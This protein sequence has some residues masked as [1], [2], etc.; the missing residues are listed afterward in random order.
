MGLTAITYMLMTLSPQ[1]LNIILPLNETRPK[2]LPFPVEYFINYEEN[3]NRILIH[4][5]ITTVIEI[6]V[7]IGTKSTFTVLVEHACGLFSVVG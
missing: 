2:Q 7:L 1:I 6:C 5:S 3:F 4:V